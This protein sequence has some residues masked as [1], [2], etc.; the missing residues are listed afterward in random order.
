MSWIAT[1]V[2]EEEGFGCVWLYS[3]LTTAEIACSCIL[4]CHLFVRSIT[5]HSLNYGS[6]RTSPQ[7]NPIHKLGGHPSYRKLQNSNWETEK[8]GGKSR[9]NNCSWPGVF[10]P[11]EEARQCWWCHFH[12]W[13]LSCMIEN[14]H[15]I[16]SQWQTCTGT[17]VACVWEV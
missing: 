2:V 16:V 15:L 1:T 17:A 11:E 10:W 4:P 8:C 6:L 5:I 7:T 13:K 12:N 3:V 14:S 9:Q